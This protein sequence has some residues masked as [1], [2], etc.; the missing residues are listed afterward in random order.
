MTV[1]KMMLSRQDVEQLENKAKR[2]QKEHMKA[3]WYVKSIKSNL[4]IQELKD[5]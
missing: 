5:R 2:E 4:N 1:N 3:N